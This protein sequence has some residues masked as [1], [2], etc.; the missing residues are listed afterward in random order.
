[1]MFKKLLIEKILNGSKTITSRDKPLYRVGEV[2]NLMANKDYSK[3]TGK[4]IKITKV[5]EKSLSKFTDIDAR[6]E[7][8]RD[9]T[10]FMAY[11]NRNIGLWNPTKSVFVH[12]FELVDK[13]NRM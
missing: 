5:Y 3:T 8:F 1:M 9:L 6:K 12:E 2:T 4:Y 11:W 13:K 10:D 7:G